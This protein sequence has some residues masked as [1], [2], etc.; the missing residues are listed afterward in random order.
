MTM[1][2]FATA[3]DQMSNNAV[4]NATVCLIG[5][6]ILLVH[7]VNVLLKKNRR[8]DENT[9]LNFLIFTAIHFAIYFT[10]T[11]IK[12]PYTNPSNEFTMGFYTVFYICNN[13]EVFLLFLYFMVYVE[14]SKKAKK[15]MQIVNI[16]LFSVFVVLDIVNIFTRMFFT[17]IE[18][19]Y[20]RAP[21]MVI[22][23]GYQ[24]VM[25]A[26]ILVVAVINKKLNNREKV[27]FSL[28]CLLPLGAIVAQNLLP[29]Y[30]IAYLSIIVAIE[31][32][33]FF[34]NVEKNILLAQEREKAKD[35]QIK[36]MLS[37]IQPHFIY[38]SLSSISTL[39]TLDPEKA[40]KALD[41][42][43][44]YLRSNLSSL[45]ARERVPFED[46]LRHTK[47]FVALEQIRFGERVKVIYDIKVSDF[48]VPPLTIQPL[49]ENAVK[50][51]IL[52]KVEGGTVIL[53]TYETEDRY[54]VEIKDDGVGFDME[55]VDFKSNEHV[56]LNNIRYRLAKMGSGEFETQSKPMEGTTVRVSFK[57]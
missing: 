16:S 2:S 3:M 20:T 47:T 13:V 30:A 10:Y 6:F 50:H 21:T 56:G 5:I 54:V 43:T 27:A 7:I 15:S 53:S 1:L 38:N 40:Q 19:A 18:G 55:S 42:F 31:V 49:V 26:M 33:F 46:E 11:V 29:G 41:D 37:Q 51:G 52:K 36:M 12:I 28:Y 14:M 8:K 24:F 9:L 4:F 39:I 57:K 44:E 48:E 22:S 34:V 45:T 35:A 17:S 23:Q 25:F 32:L